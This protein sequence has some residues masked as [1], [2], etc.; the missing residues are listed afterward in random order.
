MTINWL[1]QDILSFS[2]DPPSNADHALYRIGCTL[3]VS[4]LITRLQVTGAH[5]V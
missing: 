4:H 3:K 1:T 2:D 5:G